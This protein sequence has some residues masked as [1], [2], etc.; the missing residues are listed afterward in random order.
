[1]LYPST[2]HL[3]C[4][5]VPLT[6][7]CLPVSCCCCF[8]MTQVVQALYGKSV[9]EVILIPLEELLN[10]SPRHFMQLVEYALPYALLYKH[11]GSAVEVKLKY[12][13]EIDM[14]R[15]RL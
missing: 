13:K 8:A 9:S 4:L 7:S 14:G 6:C 15:V 3:P 2:Q 11:S 1:M 5:A 10:Q 12:Q